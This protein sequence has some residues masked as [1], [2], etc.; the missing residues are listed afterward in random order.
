MRTPWVVSILFIVNL[1]P[2]L[3]LNLLTASHKPTRLAKDPYQ[4]ATAYAAF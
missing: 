2:N 3:G 1:P 4:A